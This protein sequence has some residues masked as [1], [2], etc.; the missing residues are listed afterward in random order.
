M[1]SGVLLDL[2][3]VLYSGNEPLPGSIDAVSRLRDTELPIRF[4]TNTT[5]AP[6]RSILEKLRRLGFFCTEDELFTP[7]TVAK[8]WLIENQT[9][10]HLLMNPALEEDFIGIPS[11]D[12][13]AVVVGDAG[14]A[15]TYQQLD[16][17]F[18]HL[19]NGAE[20]L[21][22]AR[23][24]T[25]LND[26]GVLSLDVGAFVAALEYGSRK[27][28][29]LFGK[30]APEFFQSAVSSMGCDP[31]V[32][33]MVGDDAEFDVS[34]ALKAGIGWG[35]LVRTGKY[36]SGVEREVDPAPTIVVDNLEQAVEWI[37]SET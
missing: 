27:Q 35:V 6:K 24:R 2:S 17:A 30:P 14:D 8:N 13:R 22:L 18:R 26:E 3:G 5:S 19:I 15:I 12:K 9:S 28:A 36:Q 29:Q 4:L 20:F 31:A 21:A 33:A 32:I 7:A 11:S 37:I 25:Y 10:P 16:T 34:G 23:N 1:I